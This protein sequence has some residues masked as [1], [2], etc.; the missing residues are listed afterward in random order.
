MPLTQIQVHAVISFK[1]I[2]RAIFSVVWGCFFFFFLC[3]VEL[4]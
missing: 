2:D 4:H 1:I 3:E